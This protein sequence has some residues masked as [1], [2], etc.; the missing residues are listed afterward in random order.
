MA[1]KRILIKLI[2]ATFSFFCF[3]EEE[4]DNIAKATYLSSINN[5]L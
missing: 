5:R 2:K 4:L 3:S 1:K